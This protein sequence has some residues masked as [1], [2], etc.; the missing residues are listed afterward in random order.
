MRAFST[1][2][3]VALAV[4]PGLSVRHTHHD[5]TTSI[6]QKC[7][8]RVALA[9]H[10]RHPVFPRLCIMLDVISM[11]CFDGEDMSF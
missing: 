11:V 8:P 9:K 10:Y 7:R 1:G 5:T 2:F 6:L 3:S 4:D